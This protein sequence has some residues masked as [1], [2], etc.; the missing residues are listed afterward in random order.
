[1]AVCDD[2]KDNGSMVFFYIDDS[3]FE[4]VVSSNYKY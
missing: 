4:T 3:A 1:M 2:I